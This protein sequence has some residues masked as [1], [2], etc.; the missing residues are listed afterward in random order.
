MKALLPHVAA[1][2]TLCRERVQW[3]GAAALNWVNRPYLGQPSRP[4]NDLV[5]VLDDLVD[6][7]QPPSRLPDVLIDVVECSWVVVRGGRSVLSAEEGY[8]REQ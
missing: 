4:P 8:C 6:G 7:V 5:G 3:V 2:S 1:C